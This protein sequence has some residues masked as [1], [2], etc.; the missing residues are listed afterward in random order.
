MHLLVIVVDLHDRRL[1]KIVT[2]HADDEVSILV[3][4]EKGAFV[5]RQPAHG[6]AAKL[7][8]VIVALLSSACW[9]AMALNTELSSMLRS[10]PV[11]SVRSKPRPLTVMRIAISPVVR[12]AGWNCEICDA[13]WKHPGGSGRSC[14]RRRLRRSSLGHRKTKHDEN[15]KW[16]CEFIRN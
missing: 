9:R 11:S 12:E 10:M 14:G 15:E 1:Q 13:G 2:E 7:N 16:S 5:D 3:A 4:A 6:C 8:C